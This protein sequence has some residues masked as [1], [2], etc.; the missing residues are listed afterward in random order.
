MKDLLF[1]ICFIA[2]FLLGFSIA[3]WSLLTTT[4]QVMW[5][6]GDG[7][8]NVT[9]LNGG[10]GL[11]SWQILRDVINYGV[12]KIF[13]QVDSIGEKILFANSFVSHGEILRNC[14]V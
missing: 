14:F 8:T 12:W 4:D 7:G 1:F 11:W 2:I 5:S 3:S 10:S 6:Y 9:L 13:G